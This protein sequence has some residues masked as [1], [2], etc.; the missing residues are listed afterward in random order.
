[1]IYIYTHCTY[2][3]QQITF[4]FSYTDGVLWFDNYIFSLHTLA[5]VAS[6]LKRSVWQRLREKEG[7][8]KK[9]KSYFYTYS[10]KKL[11]FAT[12][13]STRCSGALARF[14]RRLSSPFG[15]WATF[16]KSVRVAC[17]LGV[18]SRVLFF[19][20]SKSD[21][22]RVLCKRSNTC[23]A[24]AAPSMLRLRMQ[25][26]GSL[27]KSS[28]E[29][30]RVIDHRPHLCL[31]LLDELLG[32]G[33]PHAPVLLRDEGRV[34]HDAHGRNCGCTVSSRGPKSR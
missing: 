6:A 34:G 7:Q 20:A 29:S 5:Y 4:S 1:M 17:I 11:S 27:E 21:I 10:I 33:A 23:S 14:F 18:G 22:V 9:K 2:I 3:S 15:S 13:L 19:R 12:D 16:L 30:D 32:S 25:G 26:L 8:R 24:R 28:L 31:E